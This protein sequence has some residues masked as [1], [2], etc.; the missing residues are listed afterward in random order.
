M[1]PKYDPA[2]KLTDERTFKATKN[3]ATLSQVLERLG[4]QLSALTA[5]HN[6]ALQRL[7]ALETLVGDLMTQ[8]P[9]GDEEPPVVQTSEEKPKKGP[10]RPRKTTA[11]E[12]TSEDSGTG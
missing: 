5:E 12:T 8:P 7:D 4:T 9:S 10:G 3:P 2:F 6:V 1:N 11:K